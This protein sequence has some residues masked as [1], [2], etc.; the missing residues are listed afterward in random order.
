MSKLLLAFVAV[1]LVVTQP[2]KDEAIKQDRKRI[3]G[4]WRIVALEVNGNIVKEEDT[5]KLTVVNGSDGMWSLRSE[6][7]EIAKGTSTIDP[8]KMPK[9]LDFI[10]T[11]GEG[12]GR[13]CLAIYEVAENTRRMCFAPPGKDRPTAFTSVPGSETVLVTFERQR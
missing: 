6:G 10:Q 8:T 3:E 13:Q 7:N 9:T 12:R 5:K 1:G 11:E 2:A 4:T